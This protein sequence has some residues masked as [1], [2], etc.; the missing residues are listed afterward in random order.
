MAQSQETTVRD[1]ALAR[2]RSGA[3]A[4]AEGR[5]EQAAEDLVYA[6]SVFRQIDDAEHAAES[7][8]TLGE[9]QRRNGAIDQAAGSYERAIELYK[10]AGAPPAREAGVTLALGHIERQRGQLDRAWEH[11]YLA[12]RLFE[13]A[14]STSGQASASLALG[15]VERIRGRLDRAAEYYSS[16]RDLYRGA[17][18]RF[19]EADA[20]RGLADMLAGRARFDEAEHAYQEALTLYRNARD[21]FGEVDTLIGL[22]RLDIDRVRFDEGGTLFGQAIA[23]ADTIEYELGAADGTLGLAEIA[24][25]RG[26]LGQALAAA[27]KAQEAYSTVSSALGEA[28]SNRVLGEVQIRRGQLGQAITVFDRAAR[29]FKMLRARVPYARALLGSGEAQR[30]KAN[31]RKAEDLFAE[32]RV[33][34]DETE[35]AAIA[36]IAMLGLGRIARQRGLSTTT[37]PLLEQSAIQLEAA[38]RPG[39][40]AQA[41]VERARLAL[42]Q[43][44][45][46]LAS[47]LAARAR[48]LAAAE[49]HLTGE[50]G[51]ITAAATVES[52]IALALNRLDVAH[53][54]AAEALNLSERENDALPHVEALLS[55]GGVE[56]RSENLDA[57]VAT[58]ND[59]LKEAKASEL[60]VAESMA[61][62]G[63]ARVLLRRG[64]WEEAALGHQEQIARLRA[65]DEA[66]ALVLAQIGVAAARH[67]QGE[68]AAA[69]QAYVEAQR[70]AVQSDAVL[71]QAEALHGE[72]RVL[73]DVPEIEAAVG[74]FTQALTLIERVG[75][76]LTDTHD[77]TSF[78]DGR[79]AIYADAIYASAREQ[80][81]SRALELARHYAGRSDRAGHAAAGQRLKEYEQSIPTRGADLTKEQIEQNKAIARILS[82]ARQALSR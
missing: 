74:R 11:Y 42:T 8:A 33:V 30:R 52:A 20:A 18:D 78:Y 31:P 47:G 46:G 65:A 12:L 54:R 19:G 71:S 70:L 60:A 68:L 75:D 49:E 69:R 41:M 4:L 76:A 21:R 58:Y 2:L 79:A 48:E 29:A 7:R 38:N 34:G 56:L 51:P 77:Q 63:L 50:P 36:A 15:H 28:E 10:Q 81:A 67:G 40:A 39:A 32:A 80:N 23:L 45:L 16:A 73:L 6:E 72:A 57:A 66:E 37:E 64:L 13:K 5:I 24:L 27:V 3:T 61:H 55:R 17:H 43:G 22:G 1:E 26:Q 53:V 25:H 59:V 44:K 9:V 82:D 35:H 14:G 62:I